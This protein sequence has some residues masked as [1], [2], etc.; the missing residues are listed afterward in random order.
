VSPSKTYPTVSRCLFGSSGAFHSFIAKPIVWQLQALRLECNSWSLSWFIMPHRSLFFVEVDNP[1]SCN[2]L[3][4]WTFKES[5]SLEKGF[6]SLSACK[7]LIQ[8]VDSELLSVIPRVFVRDTP[9]E[10][11]VIPRVYPQMSAI[12]RYFDCR[13]IADTL[14]SKT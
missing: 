4:F 1:K 6:K 2:L 13:G 11:S 10:M 12:P 8:L 5:F 14:G 3:I 9:P 7:T